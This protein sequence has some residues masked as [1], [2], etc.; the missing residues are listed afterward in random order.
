M[1]PVNLDRIAYLPQGLKLYDFIVAKNR[2][3]PYVQPTP[4]RYS[5]FLSHLS[6]AEVW[7]KLESLQ[8][9][10]SFKVRGAVHKLMRL[11]EAGQPTGVVTASAGNHALGVAYAAE[12]LDLTGVTVFIPQTAPKAKVEKLQLYPISLC[13][14]GQTYEAAH[15]AAE[16]F[17]AQTGAQYISAYDDVDIV[18]GQGTC[19]LE[20]L[21]DLP[22]TDII[23]TPTGGGGL[24]SGVALVAKAINPLVKI[25][26]VQPEASPAAKLSLEQ[27]RPIDPYDH[28]PTLADGL[29]GGFGAIPFALAAALVEQIL[30]YTEA[31][32]R[33]AIFT[34]AHQEQLVVEASG[35][36]AI[37]PLL[38]E[39]G[40]FR[41]ERVVC[42]LTGANIDSVLLREILAH[43]LSETSSD[44]F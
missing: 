18:L 8:P 32:L 22:K 42:I 26:G 39:P 41:G 28:K 2:I 23:L 43:P 12:V 4:I 11:I 36:I 40:L 37:A 33:R 15:Q 10:G 21:L 30:L 14:T 6:G 35:A 9:T 44:N 7:L 24:L 20:I 25:I 29:A 34:L 16:A 19:G 5:K 27:K 17:A 1:M 31:D 38:Q 13:Q 3:S